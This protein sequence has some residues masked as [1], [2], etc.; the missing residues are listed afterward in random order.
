M[1]DESQYDKNW[2]LAGKIIY[3]KSNNI[4]MIFTGSSALNLGYTADAARRLNKIEILPLT[5]SH[6]LKLKYGIN[7]NNNYE[8]LF[9]LLFNGNIDESQKLEFET[10][11]KLI[12]TLE[13]TTVDWDKYI[14]YGG[15][16][17][18]FNEKDNKIIL[19][20]IVEMTKKV[21]NTD[22]LNIKNISEQNQTY[23]NRI[24]RYLASVESADISKNKISKYLNTPSANVENILNILEKTGLLFHLEAY[25]TSSKRT[26]NPGNTILQQAV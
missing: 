21:V 14:F 9:D 13:Y 15:Y 26:R 2:S 22:M 12:N 7:L 6:H 18:Y 10:R 24:I 25:G 20:K 16:P 3:D 8:I 19:D 11:N 4:F 1:I 5:Y 23:S 17:V